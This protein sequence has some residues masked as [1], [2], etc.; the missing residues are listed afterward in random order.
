VQAAGFADFAI[1]WRA[2]VFAGAPQQ[3]SAAHFGTLGINFR[4][5]KTA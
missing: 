3:S 1:T 4:A 2:D 5:T